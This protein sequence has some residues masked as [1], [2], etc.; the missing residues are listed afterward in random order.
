MDKFD[1][2]LGVI[3]NLLAIFALV[4]FILLLL[5]NSYVQDLVKLRTVEVL[6]IKGYTYYEPAPENFGKEHSWILTNK[7]ESTSIHNLKKGNVLTALHEVN[8]RAAAT[9]KSRRVNFV[10]K[11]KCVMVLDPEAQ[12]INK[13]GGGWVFVGS[14]SC[15]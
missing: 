1:K 10:Q 8:I 15:N 11:N 7:Q 3:T 14:T 5:G 13:D 9:R 6:G 12:N 4:P 2:I